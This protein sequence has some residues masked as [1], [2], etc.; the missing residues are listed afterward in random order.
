MVLI[1]FDLNVALTKQR[2]SLGVGNGGLPSLG[3]GL[4]CPLNLLIVN[5]TEPLI[6]DLSKSRVSCTRNASFFSRTILLYPTYAFAV[7]RVPFVT[8]QL[9]YR[10][11][12]IFM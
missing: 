8:L 2:N 1:F 7:C 12:S 6:R 4:L 11:E 10:L 9:G 5:A 3:T